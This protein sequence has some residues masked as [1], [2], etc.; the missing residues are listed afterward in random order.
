[1]VKVVVVGSTLHMAVVEVV[2]VLYKEV[3]VMVVVVNGEGAV[4][5]GQ[6][7]VV[8]VMNRHKQVAEAENVGA[9]AMNIVVVVGNCNSREEE[10]VEYTGEQVVV[11]NLVAEVVETGHNK[12]EL[13]KAMEVEAVGT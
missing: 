5:S 1:M 9:E 3:E 2:V 12:A 6:K 7:A 11:A 13:V 8:V 10:E 4:E